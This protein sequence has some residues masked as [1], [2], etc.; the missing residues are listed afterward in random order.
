MDE[1]KLTEQIQALKKEK[2]EALKKI[3]EL[4]KQVGYKYNLGRC[5]R[6]NFVEACM[7]IYRFI[8]L[9]DWTSKGKSKTVKGKS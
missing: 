1:K 4:Q 5:V 3:S 2:E 9:K 8:F 6:A 7:E